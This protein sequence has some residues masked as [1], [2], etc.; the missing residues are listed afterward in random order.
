M[1]AAKQGGKIGS[2]AKPVGAER[3]L[4]PCNPVL[5]PL[6]HCKPSTLG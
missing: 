1:K 2:P 3:K 5:T 6:Y 4:F